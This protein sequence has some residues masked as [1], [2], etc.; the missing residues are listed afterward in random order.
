MLDQEAPEA[1]AITSPTPRQ[2]FKSTP[3][4]N[5][6]SEANDD[7]GVDYYQVGYLYDDGHTF[8]NSTC[9]DEKIDGVELSGCRD[10]H[11]TSR[12][13]TPNNDEQGGVTI[14]VRAVDNAGNIGPW[15]KS[16]HYYYDH[17]APAT[18]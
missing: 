7:H 8:G 10:V 4:V 14:W 18:D 11:G 16:V 3:I 2:W 12:D 6:W 5:S 13:H 15:S 17:E 9:E 1:P